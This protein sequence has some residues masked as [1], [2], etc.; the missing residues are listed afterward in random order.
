MAANLPR[1]AGV[2][3]IALHWPER[4]IPHVGDAVVGDGEPIPQFAME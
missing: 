1:Q 3:K 2:G 4:K